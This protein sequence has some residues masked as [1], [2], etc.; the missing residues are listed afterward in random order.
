MSSTCRLAV[1]ELGHTR[2]R[3]PPSA[4]AK[5][6]R[7]EKPRTQSD[8]ITDTRRAAL[9]RIG[10]GLR[11]VPS[12]TTFSGIRLQM[13]QSDVPMPLQ[14]EEMTP[15]S[16]PERTRVDAV[17]PGQRLNMRQRRDPSRWMALALAHSASHAHR[18][19]RICYGR[20]GP[21]TFSSKSIFLEM[22][23]RALPPKAAYGV[24]TATKNT[25]VLQTVQRSGSWRTE[26]V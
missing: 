26:N 9:S 25:L 11:L 23:L 10:C 22:R 14:W 3:S 7:A 20:Y 6:I 2:P 16:T 1:L 5:K 8:K 21:A 4:I 18:Y 15:P 13:L 12:C 19:C 24:V 17:L